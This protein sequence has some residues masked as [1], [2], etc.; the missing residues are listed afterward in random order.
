MGESL[1]E[2]IVQAVTLEESGG[3]GAQGRPVKA[4]GLTTDVIN[5]NRRIYPRAVVEEAL[6]AWNV[7][8]DA[9]GGKGA[10]AATGEAEHPSDKLSR[11]NILETVVRWE[12]AELNDGGQVQIAGRI[13]P[14]AKGR[15]LIAILESGVPVGVSMR[16]WGEVE[17]VGA[18]SE[19]G[20]EG[21]F[22][23]Y[24]RVTALHIA[25]WDF[26]A[27][28]AD[29]GGWVTESVNKEMEMEK[30]ST[31][32]PVQES[33]GVTN[34]EVARLKAELEEANKAK[35]ELAERKRKDAVEAA[36]GEAT[37]DLPY[38]NLNADFVQAVRNAA[39]DSPEAVKA[40]A[41]AKRKEWDGLFAKAK[42]Q[43]MGLQV[44][45]PVFERETGQPEYVRAAW[46]INESL[47]KAG[48]GKR[49]DYAKAEFGS[50]LWAN[51]YLELFDRQYK[52]H[53][54]AEARA[55]EEAEQTSDLSLPYSVM[56]SIIAQ[57]FP[58]L[59][60]ANIFDFGVADSSP[61]KIFFETY[62]GESGSTASVTDEAI[63][64]DD[65]TWVA[66]TKKRLQPGTVV[67]TSSPAG[68]TYVEGTDYVIDYA[69]GRIMTLSG[70][71]IND[72]TA[73]LVD[74]SYDAI[75][76]G[77]MQPI[78]R[79]KQTLASMTLEIAAD[80]LATQI[81]DEA[82][83]FSRSQLGYDAVTRTLS[84]LVRQVRE[85]IDT[86]IIRL[87][88]AA[89]LQQ[90]N[91][92]GGTWTSASDAV[93]LLVKYIGVAK[94]KVEN[95]HYMPSGILM[96]KTNADALSNWDG[97]TRDGFPDAVLS[98]AG[99]AGSV[100][101]LPIWSTSLMPDGYI[102][103]PNRELV[104]HRVFQPMQLKGPFPSYHTDGKLIAADQWYAE[105]YNGDEV[106]VVQKVAHVLVA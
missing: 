19:G 85:K 104:M 25:G 63:T 28:P 106:P 67:V 70:G 27:E 73:L 35:V 62:A 14:T 42:L 100:K 12:S 37:K 47:I 26:V 30:E 95:R 60:A 88:L 68:T 15:D 18:S 91:N 101:G 17:Q 49:H 61:T 33:T 23:P 59:V 1:N 2:S 44:L 90:A 92:S 55:F 97:F 79:A 11:R 9:N 84:G 48:Q 31:A 50:L 41:E 102:L 21:N 57:A 56:R 5:A 20:Y 71:A 7:E 78:E 38:G 82:V 103:V 32:A 6:A 76:K 34:E 75:R 36:I 74:F 54:V 51:R 89:S 10:G 99:Y 94:V 69:N 46:E 45:G 3:D 22:E 64:S 13:I 8:K 93:T 4:V 81:S 86:G 65:D 16:G 43:N 98:A 80:R 96:S 66:L 40:L 29:P 53:L 105:E 87:A 83:K 77:E 39:P 58:E 72:A 24:A 52:R